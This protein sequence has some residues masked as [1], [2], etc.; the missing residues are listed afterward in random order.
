LESQRSFEDLR[1]TQAR[2]LL[3]E[4]TASQVRLAAILSHEL[5]SPVGTLRSAGRITVVPLQKKAGIRR[6]QDGWD[7]RR[8]SSH[9]GGILP[10]TQRAGC[11]PEKPEGRLIVRRAVQCASKTESVRE[12]VGPAPQGVSPASL[13]PAD[14]LLLFSVTVPKSWG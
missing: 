9:R 3:S 2:L 4:T 13:A 5:N 7:F 11:P 10:A 8:F 12:S 1:A 6:N 14:V